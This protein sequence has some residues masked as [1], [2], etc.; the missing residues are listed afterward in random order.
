MIFEYVVREMNNEQDFKLLSKRQHTLILY[1]LH[2]V[3]YLF[4]NIDPIKK[5]TI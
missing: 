5:E 2:L 3:F 1:L 4:N